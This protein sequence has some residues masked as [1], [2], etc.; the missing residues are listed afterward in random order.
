MTIAQ[1]RTNL[2]EEPNSF[3]GRE[4]EVGELCR[5]VQLMRASTLCGTGG[6]GKTR[7][8]QRLLAALADDFP[9][10]AWF[11]ELGD[12]RQPDLVVSRVASVVGVDEERGRPLVETLAEA[13]RPRTMLLALD[14]CEHLI[15]ACAQ[16]CQRLLASSAGLR[17]IVTS[18]EPLR[19]A[20]EAVWQVPPLSLPPPDAAADV[21]GLSGYE[22][23]RLFADRA[24]AAHP[25]FELS[26]ANAASIAAI[27]RALDGVPLAI[28]LAAAWV[29]ALSAEQIA[30]RLTDR[31]QL[32]TTGDRTAPAR[33]RTLRAT[34][35]WS[36]DLLAAREQVLL[37]RLAVFSG[38]SLEMA[39]QVCADDDLP[40]A[41]VLDLIAGLVDKSLVVV[42]PEA[43][44]QSRYR[45]LDTIRDYA[46]QRLADAGEVA[47]IQ[48][49]LRDYV[50]RV[51]EHNA[52]IGMALIP[53]P[54]S[55]RVEVFRR[56]DV[57]AD[58]A[59]GVLD[60][61]LA[62]GDAATG[63]RIC[64]AIRPC[65]LVRGSY[66]EGTERFDAFLAIDPSGVPAGV[67]GPALVGRA[68]LTLASDLVGA[69]SWARA[70]L[71]ICR[72]AGGE[73]WTAVALNLL[74]EITLHTGR[75]PEAEALA[76]EALAL[77]RSVGDRLAEGYALG[78]RA[79][80]VGLRGSLREAQQLAEAA[81]TVMREI[82]HQWGAARTL[83]G[84]GELDRLRGD[85][86][87]ARRRYLEAL[88]ILREIDS[89]PETA[90]CLAGLGRLAMEQGMIEQAREHLA[91]SIRLSHSTGARIGVARGLEAFAALALLEDRADRAVQ[92]IAA[93]AALRE[94]AHLPRLPGARTDGYFA[95]AR[96]LGEPAIAQLWSCG[97]S[98]T[99][100]AA[101]A[102][103]LDPAQYARTGGGEH[104]AATVLAGHAAGA[105]MPHGRLTTREREIVALI[106]G[107]RSNKAIADELFIS[108]AT[109]ARHVANIL[110][111]LGFNSRAQV[112]AWA[113]ARNAGPDGGA[114][115]R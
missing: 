111:K 72:A 32:L 103:A 29:R 64:T 82:D 12:V 113:S 106:A 100:E 50:L 63:L 53:A 55:D 107:G 5:F 78:T 105:P 101:V 8:A 44:G 47:A 3:V 108:P 6:I 95:A 31:F 11:V 85:P 23:V 17:I 36:H 4:R 7:L 49:R 39:E 33:Q 75:A 35:D 51:V 40:A 68:Q 102:A 21:A 28:E 34:I 45:L 67:R 58:N 99:S 92:L 38:W 27:C 96:P 71:E 59:L 26:L 91:E 84:L 115:S 57:D 77:A 25:G 89:R 15:D 18:R 109:A 14:N 87:G 62:D 41:V 42:E 54:W 83:L 20:A 22:S 73:V 66:A 104:G 69:E 74:A 79:A 112:A 90:R 19:V 24:A 52:A 10:G 48:A 13:L 81:I 98:M 94:A 30:E 46:A 76:D 93:A 60:H 37:R 65:W 9:D 86:D 70:G 1:F 43:L 88:P 110:E 16:L 61:C 56:Y 114:V 2:H 80:C 97:F